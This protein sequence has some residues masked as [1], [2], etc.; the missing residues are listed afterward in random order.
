MC[1]EKSDSAKRGGC[2]NSSCIRLQQKRALGP[3]TV[4]QLR[5][6]ILVCGGSGERP[7]GNPGRAGKERDIRERDLQKQ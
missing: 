4:L 5:L 1:I 6:T 3:C 2:F 7:M